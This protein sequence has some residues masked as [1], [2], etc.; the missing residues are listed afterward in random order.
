MKKNVIFTSNMYLPNTGGI[1][2]SINALAKEAQDNGDLATIVTSNIV[3]NGANLNKGEVFEQGTRVVRYGA[4]TSRL[5]L[6]RVVSYIYNALTTYRAEYKKHNRDTIVIA[7][8]HWNVFFAYLAGFR[9]IRYL[10]PGVVKIQ[11][12]SKNKSGSNKISVKIESMVQWLAFKLSCKVFVFSNT[13]MQQ[14]LSVYKTSNIAKVKPGIDFSRFDLKNTSSN[15]NKNI[16]VIAICRLVSAKGLNYLIDAM[17]FL[18]DH[19]N[20]VLAGDG[21]EKGRLISLAKKNNVSH[22][23]DF[24]G[25]VMKPEEYYKSS[26]VF[27][28]PS[29]YEPF[30]QTILEA[31]S[32]GLPV[33]AFKS[34]L[35]DTATYDILGDIGFYANELTAES[36]SL[37]IIKAY[38]LYDE[39]PEYIKRGRNHVIENYSWMELYRNLINR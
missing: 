6:V 24:V 8:Y 12:D 37:E 38:N 28:L 23:V 1:E 13:M 7:R 10:V 33:V 29:I 36:L 34:D 2:N 16:Q 3:E 4:S 19:Y 30:G 35:V 31:V 14:V 17:M 32:S 39:N 11:N 25:K 27:V 21:P 26:D 20:L 5:K 18:P 15:T 9:N 22:R